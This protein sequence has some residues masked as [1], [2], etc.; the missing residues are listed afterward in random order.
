MLLRERGVELPA[1][2]DRIIRTILATDPA[3]RY[4]TALAAYDDLAAVLERHNS[5]T[6]IVPA[7]KKRR[8]P[9]ARQLPQV[10]EQAVPRAALTDASGCHQTLPSSG[11]AQSAGAT[12]TPARRTI[13]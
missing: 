9:S 7:P 8:V 4:P 10:T 3:K 13:E 5:A 12:I 11:L 2:V 6:V 1:D